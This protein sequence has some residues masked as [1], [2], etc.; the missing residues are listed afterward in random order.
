VWPAAAGPRKDRPV[1]PRPAAAASPGA[2]PD[3]SPSPSPSSPAESP[4]PGGG[5]TPSPG[6]SGRRPWTSIHNW[7]YWIDQPRLDQIGGSSYEL[8]VID[9]SGDGTAGQEFSAAQIDSLRRS[10]CQRRVL[11]YFSIGEAEDY[12]FYWQRG[13]RPG[14]PGIIVGQNQHWKGNYYVRY[15]DPEWQALVF[16]YLDRILKAGFDGVYLDRVDAYQ[17]PHARGHEQEMVDLVKGIASYARQRSP[18]GDD[19]GVVVQNAEELAAR[20]ADYLTVTT[21]IGREEVYYADTNQATSSGAQRDVEAN[22]DLFKRGSR[23]RLV[24]TV[25]YADRADLVADAYRKS[26]AK[27]YV[28]YVTSVGLEGMRV[29]RG[30]EPSCSSS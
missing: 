9:Y 23:G 2:S 27:G 16:Q 11:A 17:D 25:D 7:T 19:F 4:S 30:F 28:P 8:A 14:S 6:G 13:W 26:Q 29:N 24:L 1:T 20:H 21:G 15:W 3:Q 12:R 5:I 18:L 22:L 10:G